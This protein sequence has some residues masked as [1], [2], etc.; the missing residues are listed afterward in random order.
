MDLMTILKTLFGS[1]ALTFEQFAEKLNGAENLKLGN[2]ADGKYVDKNKYDDLSNQLKAVNEKYADY[3]DIKQKLSSAEADGEKKLNE[4]KL[5]VE[6]A[7]ALSAANA[8]DEVSVKANL[9][10]D[11]IKFDTDGKIS[12]LDDQLKQLKA[13]KPFLFKQESKKS[14]PVLNLGGSTPGAKTEKS[15]GIKGAVEDFYSDNNE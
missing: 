4:Y 7:K 8:A 10:M 6:I 12:G 11:N 15:G 2:L 5:Q 14:D 3:D 13:D 1:E 9:N